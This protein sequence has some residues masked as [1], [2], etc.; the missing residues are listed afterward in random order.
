[1]YSKTVQ[2]SKCSTAC[3]VTPINHGMYTMHMIIYMSINMHRA[4]ICMHETCSDL[5][6]QISHVCMHACI[7]STYIKH[8]NITRKLSF[9]SMIPETWKESSSRMMDAWWT[10]G[11]GM[12]WEMGY[13]G[14]LLWNVLIGM[15]WCGWSWVLVN[16]WGGGGGWW[17]WRLTSWPSHAADM[18]VASLNVEASPIPAWIMSKNSQTRTNQSL[19]N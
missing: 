17:W 6:K 12:I 11:G 1:M 2:K 19:I 18:A 4:C 5:H 14:L 15:A 3:E 13:G 10:E 8:G 9:W 16:T 7:L